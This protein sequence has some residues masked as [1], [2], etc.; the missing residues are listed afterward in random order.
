[1]PRKLKTKKPQTKTE[2]YFIAHHLEGKTKTQAVKEAGISDIRNVG[3]IEKTKTYQRLARTYADVI[4]NQ[5]SMDETVAELIKNV[6]QDQDKGAKNNAIKMLMQR[7]EPEEQKKQEEDKL[8]V[9]LR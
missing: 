7:V 9:V 6:R 5:I 1:M 2:K 8:I 4:D 3:H